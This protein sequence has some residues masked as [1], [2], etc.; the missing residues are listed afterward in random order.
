MILNLNKTQE[1]WYC[2]QGLIEHGLKHANPTT[3]DITNSNRYSAAPE[4]ALLR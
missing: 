4:L 2:C 1:F 3:L